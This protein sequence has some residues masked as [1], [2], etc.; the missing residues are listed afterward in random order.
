MQAGFVG[1]HARNWYCRR[2]SHYLAEQQLQRRFT[3]REASHELRKLWY[4][5]H[6][7]RIAVSAVVVLEPVIR[8]VGYEDDE[9]RLG[10]P[11]EVG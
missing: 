1:L 7:M 8:R 6:P 4:A 9:A 11:V 3:C 10:L 2:V 5:W